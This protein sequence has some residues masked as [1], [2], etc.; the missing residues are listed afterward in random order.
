MFLI[1]AAFWL[2]VAV[3]FIPADQ[4]DEQNASVNLISTGEALMAAQSVWSDLSD[5]C[6]RNPGACET[7]SAAL[8]TF[9]QK[10]KNGARI[11]YNYLDAEDPDAISPGRTVN[12]GLGDDS[13][14]YRPKPVRTTLI[15]ADGARS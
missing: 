2:S 12:A 3:L 14:A 1:R 4:S 11:V 7:G 13:G 15:R 8:A 10:A 9:S 6:L 5:F